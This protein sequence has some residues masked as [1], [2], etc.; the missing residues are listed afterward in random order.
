MQ[1]DIRKWFMKAHDKGND[2]AATNAEKKPPPTEP[3]TETPVCGGQ[4]GSG[5][6]K[7]SKYFAANKQKQKEDKEVEDLPAKRKAQ[8]DGVQSVKPLPSKKV[9]KVD[10]EEEDDD[11]SLPKKKNDA[12]PSKKLKSSSG[13]GIAQK[14]VHVNESD[15]DDVKDTES[16]LK[17]GGRG[18]GG[19]GV[20]G[21]PSGG[22]GRGG[23]RGG[24]MN[25][26]ERKDPP[27]KGEKEVPEGAPNCL[28]GLTF[29][30]SGTLDSLEREEAE[31]L[32]KRHG[33]RVTG[34]VSKKTSYL[35]C[36]EDIEGRKSSKAKELGTPFLTE[37]G[38]FDKIRSSKN[39]KA[40][41]REDSKVSVEKVASLPKKSP[42]KADLKSSSL[43]SNAA[44]KDLGAG[45]QQAK[46]KDQAIQRS[47]LIWTEKYRPKVPN[48]MIGNQ[49]LVT[50]LHNWLKNWNEQFHDT[51]NKG[52]GKKQNDSTVKK[53]V[54]LSGPPGIGKTTSAKL[55]SKMLGFQAI[56]VNASD[57]RG[58]ADAKIFKG[59]SGSNANC[60][61]EL[62]SNEA[63]GFEMDRS[64]HLKTVLI[65]DE[66][67]GMSAGDRGGVADLIASIKISK[68]PIICI[69]NDRYSQKLKSLVNYCLLLSFR[70]PTKQQMAKRLIQ[71]ANAEGLQVNEIALE[72]LAERVNGDMRMALNQ[73]H[74]MS[75][76]MSV[77]NYDDVRQRLQGSAKDEDISPFTAVDKL[78]GFSGGK[79]RMDERID[80]SMSD[81]DL[82]PLLIQENYINYRPSSLGK[83]DN[84]MKRMS[85][86]A[87]AA[88]SIADGDII[89]VQ[90]RRYRQWQLSQ[91]GSLSS[92]IIP[93]ALLHGS[94]ETLEQGE[95]NFNRF[96][97]W[98]GKNSTA[99]KNL[100]LLEDLHVHLLASRESNMARETL[101]LD[102]LTVLL[103]QLTDPL[104]VLPKDEAVEKVV[105]FMNVYS[106]SQED[107]DTIVELSKFQVALFCIHH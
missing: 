8:N 85:L 6:R 49:S 84:G 27:H 81:P 66:V 89:N 44:H 77:I 60:I 15:E 78:F 13:R 87:R 55:V 74:Y 72:E 54:L 39:S 42:Q 75:L 37:D 5:R 57:N 73:L 94:R 34:S 92:C 71:V 9:H 21:A 107:M 12:S 45:S 2:N 25:F 102:Y 36:D 83:D 76:S 63:L 51:G 103:K 93:A 91:T 4:E 30:I 47:S 58:K 95:R 88:E 53:A 14:P 17:S 22:R 97:G 61:K 29:V 86:I 52:K 90:I 28:A 65:M 69:C 104:R 35:L 100:R 64:K 46:Q 48:E 32:I 24:F 26:G 98:L 40:P 82:V 96:G 10:D 7:T 20:S 31:D 33:G 41:A 16:P 38:L 3:K 101:R 59:I 18:R 106:I 79:L 70:K 11:F 50:Q 56:E 19:R 99:G 62:I 105:E 43:M 23:G 1:R 68:I 67:D 80:L